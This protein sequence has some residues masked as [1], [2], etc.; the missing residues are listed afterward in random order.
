M[1]Q[2][3]PEQ[4]HK[5]AAASLPLGYGAT[6]GLLYALVR[7]HARSVLLE[8][9]ALGVAVWAAGY[10]G[11]LPALGLMPPLTEQQPKQIAAPL[12]Q[13][14]AFGLVV[15]SLVKALDRHS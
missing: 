13:H 6:S 4:A 14:V 5:L 12:L 8:G 3:I 2:Q 7:P 11:W 15:A 1:R 9:T 10:V